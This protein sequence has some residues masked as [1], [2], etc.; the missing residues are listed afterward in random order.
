MNG[1]AERKTEGLN[2]VGPRPGQQTRS[3]RKPE[4]RPT[5][6]L[7]PAPASACP[8]ILSGELAAGAD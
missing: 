8:H 5:M 2:G 6:C 3:G 7:G 4:A 1:C